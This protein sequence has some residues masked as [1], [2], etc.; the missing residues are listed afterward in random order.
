MYYCS[1]F[2]LMIHVHLPVI[3]M[4]YDY[5]PPLCIRI[6]KQSIVLAKQHNLRLE[7]NPKRFQKIC[8]DKRGR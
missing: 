2:E 8:S 3:F 7:K 1:S 5:P 4:R 6:A